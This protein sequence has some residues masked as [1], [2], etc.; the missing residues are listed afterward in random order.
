MSYDQQSTPITAFELHRQLDGLVYTFTRATDER[1]R[2][3]FLREDGPYWI[4]HHAVLGWVAADFDSDEI[5]GRPWDQLT[6]QSPE[7]P[8]EGIWVNRKGP[9][10]YVYDLVYV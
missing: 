6:P 4:V 7:A 2:T 1:G 9:K 8:P 10:S 5:M 3:G